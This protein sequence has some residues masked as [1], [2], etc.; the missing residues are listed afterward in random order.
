MYIHLQVLDI[1]S[2]CTLDY[3]SYM[4][5]LLVRR[6]VLHTCKV[7]NRACPIPSH[8]SAQVLLQCRV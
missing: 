6:R 8:R 2:S 3:L 5:H 1:L 7:P 4:L